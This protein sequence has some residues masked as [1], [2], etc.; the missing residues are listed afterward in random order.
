MHVHM[1]CSWFLVSVEFFLCHCCLDNVNDL[2]YRKVQREISIVKVKGMEEGE[3]QLLPVQ[4]RR[5][6]G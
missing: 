4:R 1:K 5:G 3:R 6:G 2:V